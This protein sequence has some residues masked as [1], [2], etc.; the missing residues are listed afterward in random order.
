MNWGRVRQGLPVTLVFPL[1]PSRGDRADTRR[2]GSLHHALLPR[3]IEAAR[4][5]KTPDLAALN[6][7]I[8]RF[9]SKVREKKQKK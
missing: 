3:T 8:L 7:K 9:V 2:R 4:S 1:A 5:S 6:A